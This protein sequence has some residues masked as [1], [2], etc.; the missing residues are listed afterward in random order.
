LDSETT[1][2]R[3]IKKAVLEEFLP[4]FGYGAD[5][6][7][8]G[9]AAHKFRVRDEKRLAELNLSELSHGELPDVVAY[10]S[11]HEWLY[12]IE[13]VHRSGPISPL[14]HLELS[15]L[16]SDCTVGLI[17]VSAF[18]DRKTFGK[19]SADLSWETVAWIAED[20]DHLIH[21][22]GKRFIGPY[23]DVMPE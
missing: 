20:P 19:F 10:S 16:T 5:V 6:L 17:Y 21:F 22:N 1:P 8:V 12:L 3:R 14:R 11:T 18:W 23:P 9:D 4:R 2:L 7:H 15:R 13:A